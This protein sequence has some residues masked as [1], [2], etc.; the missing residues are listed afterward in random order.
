MASAS[1]DGRGSSAVDADN[2]DQASLAQHVTRSNF[3]CGHCQR[4][5]ESPTAASRL[6]SRSAFRLEAGPKDKA[7]GI[8]RFRESPLYVFFPTEKQTQFGFLI[9][10]PYRTTPARDNIPKDDAWS[11]TLVDATAALIVEAL[12]EIK[13]RGLL[14]VAALDAL[15]IRLDAFPPDG[16]FFLHRGG[17]PRRAQDRRPSSRRGW[18]LC[19]RP[20]REARARRGTAKAVGPGSSIRSLPDQPRDEMALRRNHGKHTLYDLWTYLQQGTPDR[21]GGPRRVRTGNLARFS[22]PLV[23]PMVRRILPIPFRP[24]IAVA[25]AALAWRY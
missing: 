1:G 9:Q 18:D 13:A 8:V 6:P 11:A 17:R 22:V 21:R 14:T 15:P 19:R 4:S 2:C 5:A 23:R 7:E 25:R 16:M 10:G 24:G 3:H 12:H 20:P